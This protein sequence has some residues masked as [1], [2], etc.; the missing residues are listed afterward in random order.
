MEKP[1][2]VS[3]AV[4]FLTQIIADIAAGEI[5][6]PKFQRP[7]VWKQAQMRSLFDSI[8]NGYPIG[9]L[10]FWKTK[11]KLK[12]SE[13]IGYYKVDDISNNE[14]EK[15]YVIDGHQRLTTLFSCLYYDEKNPNTESNW[16][17]L[18]NC[19]N[20]TFLHKK[21]ENFSY[22]PIN[23]LISSK[24]ARR[25]LLQFDG[26]KTEDGSKDEIK[27]DKYTDL[28]D[29]LI[30]KIKN[31]QIP[32]TYI[33]NANSDDII[34]MFARLNS[35]GTKM[36]ADYLVSALT[37]TDELNTSEEISNLLEKHNSFFK[38]ADDNDNNNDNDRNNLLRTLLLALDLDVYMELKGKQNIELFKKA[39]KKHKGEL[40]NYISDW[41]KAIN[42]T[43]EFIQQE[44]KIPASTLFPYNLQ[45]LSIYAFFLELLNLKQEATEPQKIALTRWFWIGAFVGVNN[46]NSSIMKRIREEAKNIAHNQFE[47]KAIDVKKPAVVMSKA[48]FVPTAARGITSIL[49]YLSQS[50]RSLSTGK[51]IEME[52]LQAI[53]NYDAS[54]LFFLF[55][56]KEFGYIKTIMDKNDPEYIKTSNL[57]DSIANRIIGNN[58]LS[59]KKMLELLE[60]WES[61]DKDTFNKILESHLIPI[62]AYKA[63]ENGN[64]ADFI[65]LRFEYMKKK[66]IEFMVSKGVLP[67]NPNEANNS[68][69][70]IEEE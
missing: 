7:F 40:H 45:F 66:E 2:L 41:K 70:Y 61:A 65:E 69:P 29:T 56:K 36:H 34:D 19:E 9:S 49:F 10:V 60:Y 42:L 22:F 23:K 44:L 1:I 62:S 8:Y 14:G 37:Y 52:E 28:V 43:V 31:Y 38:N 15:I 12:I 39:I 27:A 48:K 46:T 63:L 50:P 18:F 54:A 51:A 68:E 6:I 33:E 11:E 57:R 13:K 59:T 32:I 26:F 58:K 16:E 25:Q 20:E 4:K 5:V 30:Q 35:E 67:P 64:Y 55:N 17:I 21:D 3:P 47:F 24:L 53:F